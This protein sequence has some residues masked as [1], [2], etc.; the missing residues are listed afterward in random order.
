MEIAMNL[1][2]IKVREEGPVLFAEM[3][4]PPMNLL[5]PELV[6]DL[7][8]LIQQAEADHKVQV[9]VFKSIDPDYFIAYVDVTRIMVKD[10][11]KYAASGGSAYAQFDTDGK[12]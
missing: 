8:S 11:K 4:S 9:L 7:V 2:T 1:E 5:G 10:S 12:P 6:R 3:S